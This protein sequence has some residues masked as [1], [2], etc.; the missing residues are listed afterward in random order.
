M[1]KKTQ[2]QMIKKK[3]ECKA[4]MQFQASAMQKHIEELKM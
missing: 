2:T 1:V 3:K 4:N